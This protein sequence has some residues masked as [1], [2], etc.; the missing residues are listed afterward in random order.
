MCQEAVEGL[1][2]G[3]LEPS[4]GKARPV[5]KRC[6]GKRRRRP[7]P[8]A[9]QEPQQ[10]GIRLIIDRCSS[11]KATPPESTSQAAVVQADDDPVGHS[12]PRSRPTMALGVRLNQVMA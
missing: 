4:K 1:V 2:A 11:T 7:S 9:E 10:R 3:C 8:G 12:L 5:R 6:T